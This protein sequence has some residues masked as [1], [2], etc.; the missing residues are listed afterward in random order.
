MGW[1]GPVFAAGYDGFMA[2]SERAGLA[3]MREAL[4]ARAAGRVLEIGAGTGANLRFYPDRVTELVLCEPE[5]AMARRLERR[6]AAHAREVRVLRAPAEALPVADASVDCVVSTLVLC[7]VRDPA[8]ALA[9]VRRVLRR[10]GELLFLEHVRADDARLATWQARL[11]RPW[12]WFGHGCQCDRP[13][14]ATMRA[15]GFRL[16]D[17]RSAA[18]PK[19]PP[20]V[21]PTVLG[22]AVVA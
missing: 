8:R 4:V 2:A 18:L 17:V 6:L 22:A 3:R 1:W 12:A 19:V 14:L 11:R 15:A 13:T 7:S 16:A 21:R 5:E 9:E 20:I 10:G